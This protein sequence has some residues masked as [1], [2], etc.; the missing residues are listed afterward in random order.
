MG[1]II[2]VPVAAIAY[3]FLKLVAEAQ[4]Y[5][6]TTLAERPRVPRRAELVAHARCSR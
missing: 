5:V 1:A 4:Q 2:G 3:F 6:F